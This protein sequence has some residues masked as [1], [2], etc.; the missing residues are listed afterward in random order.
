MK[1]NILRSG[2]GFF[3]FSLSLSLSAVAQTADEIIQRH[4]EALGGKDK[5][6]SLSAIYLEGVSVMQDGR[7]IGSKLWK[8][9]NR[10]YRQEINFGMGEMV[11][12][13]T[14]SQGWRSNP[15]N[16]GNFE[17]MSGDQLKTLQMQLDLAG[18]FV[19]YAAKGYTA[20]WL[21]QDTVGGSPCYKIRMTNKDG[22]AI[23]YSID[24]KTAYVARETRKGNGPFGG[25]RRGNGGGGAGAGTPGGVP[26]AAPGAGSSSVSPDA[27]YHIDFSD[28]QKTP[29]G[30]IFPFSMTIGGGPKTI[31]EKI[32]VNKPVDEAKLS[33][34][35]N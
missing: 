16:G 13:V 12:I 29:E 7:E 14:P 9:N 19:D 34:P 4:I 33:K 30:Y 23:T 35:G 2:L 1:K 17:A 24:A 31:F 28:Y 15:R 3:L 26:G 10:L 18:P 25:G 27:T 8:V 11:M 20:E 5:L 6:N 22:L 32:E 21:G